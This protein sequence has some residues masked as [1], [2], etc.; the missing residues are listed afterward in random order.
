MKDT[1]TKLALDKQLGLK[2]VKDGEV[3]KAN[4][5]MATLLDNDNKAQLLE[6]NFKKLWVASY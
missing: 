4:T 3:T 1:T 6:Y 2:K 5:D